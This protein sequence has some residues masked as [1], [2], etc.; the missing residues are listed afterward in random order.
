VRLGDF[1]KPNLFTVDC[2][3]EWTFDG[4]AAYGEDHDN[5]SAAGIRRYSGATGISSP[6]RSV[7]GHGGIRRCRRRETCTRRTGTRLEFQAREGNRG[8][9]GRRRCRA[10]P[11]TRIP[12]PLG[13]SGVGRR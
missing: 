6:E 4:V 12:S 5:W 7:V 11:F 8:W 3:T 2:L 10:G 13:E 9:A 1:L